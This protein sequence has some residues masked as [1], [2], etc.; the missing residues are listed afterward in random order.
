[1]CRE[2][3][4]DP[5][6]KRK[7]ATNFKIGHTWDVQIFNDLSY[8]QHPRDTDQGLQGGKLPRHRGRDKLVPV[9]V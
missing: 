6:T 8:P 1:M 5:L 9:Q 7:V 2:V 4:I 3:N